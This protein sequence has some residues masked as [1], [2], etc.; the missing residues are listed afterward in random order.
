M[1]PKNSKKGKKAYQDDKLPC[2][3]KKNMLLILFLQIHK[4]L[5]D[6]FVYSEFGGIFFDLR[7]TTL[8]ASQGLLLTLFRDYSH[9]ALEPYEIQGTEAK[10]AICKENAQLSG[11]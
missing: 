6:L 5:N 9:G 8:E 10:S 4:Y 7:K 1:W 2:Q 11:L 3:I